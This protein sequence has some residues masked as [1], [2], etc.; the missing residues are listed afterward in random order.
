VRTAS[1]SWVREGVVAGESAMD[2][3]TWSW[4]LY[5]PV[6]SPFAKSHV[7]MVWAQKREVSRRA[8]SNDAE[9][10]VRVWGQRLYLVVGRRDDSGSVL[11]RQ[12]ALHPLVVLQ[13]LDA[14]PGQFKMDLLKKENEK[15]MIDVRSRKRRESESENGRRVPG[16]HFPHLDRLISRSGDDVVSRWRKHYCRHIVIVAL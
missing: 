10:R 8:R 12:H 3:M 5:T 4:P 13:G 6:H 1:L 9:V 7:R 11:A 16:G 2:S 15:K 14:V